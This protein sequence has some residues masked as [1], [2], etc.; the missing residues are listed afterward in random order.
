MQLSLGQRSPLATLNLSSMLDVVYDVSGQA[1][2]APVCFL[3]GADSKALGEAVSPGQPRS[4]DGAINYSA[5]RFEVQLERLAAGV[6]RLA[7][8]LVPASGGLKGVQRGAV[9]LN[10]SGGAAAA[11]WNFT[12]AEFGTETAIIALELYRHQGAWRVMVNGQGF[13]DGLSGLVRNFAASRSPDLRAPAPPTPTPQNASSGRIDVTKPGSSSSPPSGNS[14]RSI[15][16]TK[17]TL[18][19]QGQSARISLQKAGTQ[20]V[21]VN[22]NWDAKPASA[23]PSGGGG[24]LGKLLGSVTGAGQA[25]DLDLGCMYELTSGE[26]GVIQALGGNFGKSGGPPYITLDQDDRSGASAG[27][28][29]LYIERPDL[30]RKVL[31]FAFIYEGAGNFSDVGG[32][33]S[34]TDPQGNEVKMQL[35]NPAREPFCAV[36]LVEARGGELVIT[37]EERYFSGHRDADAAFG[38]GFSWKAGRK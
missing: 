38:F 17:I 18:D 12:G 33:L 2:S 16:L 5:Q 34:F 35:S 4:T 9:S 22:L 25:A 20:R 32:R 15:S 19:K 3:L 11:T 29:N 6:E 26:K 37:K 13:A 36:A 21:H 8:C 24:F 1:E 14:G 28:E 30:I 23:A 31:I 10:T 27:G 7:F